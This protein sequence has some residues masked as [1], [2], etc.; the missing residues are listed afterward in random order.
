M[1]G[2]MVVR[3]FAAGGLKFWELR[4]GG[5]GGSGGRRAGFYGC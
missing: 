2:V 5:S 4:G 3:G 1:D